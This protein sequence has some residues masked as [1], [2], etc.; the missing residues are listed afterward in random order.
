M[1]EPLYLHIPAYE[2][3]WYRQKIMQ[4]P[5]TM[6]YNKGYDL[7]SHDCDKATGCISEFTTGRPC[8]IFIF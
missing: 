1:K 3:L 5:D 6:S 4:D 8:S 7:N 2:E